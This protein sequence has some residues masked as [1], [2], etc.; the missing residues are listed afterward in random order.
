MVE[1]KASG[2][3]RFVP[4]PELNTLLKCSSNLTFSLA[5]GWAFVETEE[6]RKDLRCKWSGYESNAFDIL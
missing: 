6:L 5:P 3:I 1:D 2:E 4:C